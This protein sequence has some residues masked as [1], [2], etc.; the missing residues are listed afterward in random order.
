M[1]TS[2][3]LQPRYPGESVASLLPPPQTLPRAIGT[4]L[5]GVAVF[6]G[7]S[8]LDSGRVHDLTSLSLSIAGGVTVGTILIALDFGQLAPDHRLPPQQA[9]GLASVQFAVLG[10]MTTH[11]LH[12][13]D[14]VMLVLVG[15]L[16]IPG[17][18]L[19]VTGVQTLR[20]VA[21]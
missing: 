3:R 21:R 13:L 16:A 5:F 11:L 2:S 12:G 18:Y 6:I 15:V 20:A 14:W 19:L 10:W 7:L 9:I 17:L 8:F 1:D 4:V